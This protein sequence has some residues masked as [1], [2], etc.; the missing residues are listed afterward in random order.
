MQHCIQVI[1]NVCIRLVSNII[2]F[3]FKRRDDPVRKVNEYSVKVFES[4]VF[5]DELKQ[6]LKPYR[7]PSRV[8]IFKI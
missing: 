3:H 8:A 2:A 5:T 4:D 6:D 7:K 1:K